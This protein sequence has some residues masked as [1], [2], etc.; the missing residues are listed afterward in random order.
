MI[1]LLALMALQA[2]ALLAGPVPLAAAVTIGAATLSITGPGFRRVRTGVFLFSSLFAALGLMGWVEHALFKSP[3]FDLSRAALL[4]LRGFASFLA[5]VAAIRLFTLPEALCFFKRLRTPDYL[6]TM[7][8]LMVQDFHVLARLAGDMGRS[9]RAR[10]AGARGWQRIRMLAGASGSFVSLA[11][12]TFRDRHEHIQARGLSLALPVEA[13]R[14]RELR[15][16]G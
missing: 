1:R 5:A 16:Q 9:I 11:V 3:A 15:H 13:W 2:L 8:Y 10:G 12:D 7:A 14:D 4:S 6:L